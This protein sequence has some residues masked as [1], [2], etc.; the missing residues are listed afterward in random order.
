MGG[1]FKARGQH[2]VDS[3]AVK[4]DDFETVSPILKDFADFGKVPQAVEDI[5]G[6]SMEIAF[7]IEV[8]SE[9]FLQGFDGSPPR[10]EP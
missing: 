1:R 7:G 6:D 9:F 4:I 8:Q 3:L 2:L 5:A 10:N